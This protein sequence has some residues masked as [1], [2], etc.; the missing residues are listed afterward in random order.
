MMNFKK[1]RFVTDSTCDI[2]PELLQKH[3]ITVV[4]CYINYGNQSYA[5]DSKELVREDFYQTL[6]SVHPSPTTAAP[7]P[8]DCKS[9]I[10]S[11]FKDA[12]HVVIVSVATKLSGTNNAL[13][14]GAADFPPDR[15]TLLDSQTTSMGLGWQVVLGAET[16]EMTGNVQQTV[17]T[18]Q[19]VQKHTHV[20]CA[21]QTLEFLRRSGR[22]GWAAAGIGALLQIKPILHV[23][24]GEVNQGSR[25]RTFSRAV[26]EMVRL[27]HTH[28]P[29]D[30]LAIM[31]A[32]NPEGA[33]DLQNRLAD[34][35]PPD[36]IIVSITPT[37]GTHIGPGG[38]GLAPVSKLWRTT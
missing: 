5:D 19:R 15:V 22:V 32:I 27:C 13:R 7:S 35:S 16:A 17:D 23:F 33:L 30:R 18:V 10:E 28:A 9:A 38:L 31:H 8:G 12:D 34:I 6:Q 1:I 3:N 36:T 25:V 4:P 2:P 37:I 21:L 11:A 26:D 14:L 24:N 29:L 20:Y